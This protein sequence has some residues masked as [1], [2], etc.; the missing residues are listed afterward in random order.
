VELADVLSDKPVPT[1]EAVTAEPVTDVKPADQAAATPS[2]AKETEP[3]KEP[4]SQERDDK[5]RYSK[6]P[7][8]V[9]GRVVALRE[10]RRKRQELE[11]KLREIQAQKPKTDFFENPEQAF[12]ERVT[13]ELAPWQ[14]RFFKLSIK[15]AKNVAGR[16]DF[17]EVT[18]AFMAAS[19]NDPALLNAFQSSDDPGEYAYTVGKQFKELGDV[20]GDIS[21]YRE[22]IDSQWKGKFGELE[23]R[24]AALEAEN[25][26]L[27]ESK[28]KIAKI[29]QS[30]NSEPSAATNAET[31]AGP[32]SLKSILS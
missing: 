4:G 3:T 9:D 23:T 11:A 27:K 19:E 29:P 5:G 2:V 14:A 28:D 24:L 17:D 13:S 7:E 21:K 15:A 16:E 18:E 20:G 1:R 6:P 22:K 30:L 8:E 25:K 12:K 32:R 31:F 10:E 26:A